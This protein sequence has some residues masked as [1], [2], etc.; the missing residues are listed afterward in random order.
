[1][2]YLLFVTNLCHS[3]P[4]TQKLKQHRD[5]HLHYFTFKNPSR[6]ICTCHYM[7]C[8]CCCRPTQISPKEKIAQLRESFIIQHAAAE[9]QT[10]ALINWQGTSSLIFRS[11]FIQQT[12]AVQPELRS[13]LSQPHPV[14]LLLQNRWKCIIA[15]LYRLASQDRWMTLGEVYV[16]GFRVGGGKV[17]AS[18]WC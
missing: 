16:C 3:Q 5:L 9:I 15:A 6:K 7:P 14:L 8:P 18:V 4:G 17:G 1:M 13:F 11:D 12:A 2:S 10:V